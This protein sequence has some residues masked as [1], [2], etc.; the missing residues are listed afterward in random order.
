MRADLAVAVL[1]SFEEEWFWLC[2]CRL[3][4]RLQNRYV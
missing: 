3:V 2:L 4:V 1:G